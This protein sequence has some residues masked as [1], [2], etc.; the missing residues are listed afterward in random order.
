MSSASP[1]SMYANPQSVRPASD[2]YDPMGPGMNVMGN[3]PRIQLVQRAQGL[4]GTEGVQAAGAWQKFLSP[5]TEF[6]NKFESILSD[7]S[8]RVEKGN[9]TTADLFQIQFQ[10][11]QLSY[12]NDLSSKIADKGSQGVQTLFRNQG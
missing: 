1:I 2:L 11:T 5:L 4:A 12:V 8:R 3:D 6:K 10:L 9:L 7:I